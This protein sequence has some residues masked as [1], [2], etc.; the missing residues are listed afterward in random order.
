M[1]ASDDDNLIPYEPQALPR[2]EPVAIECNV[3]AA[4]SIE[5]LLK[6]LS[7]MHFEEHLNANPA[8]QTAPSLGVSGGAPSGELDASGVGIGATPDEEQAGETVPDH[9][10]AKLD[11]A[12]A[13]ADMSDEAQARA[14][15]SEVIAEG[16]AA[17]RDEAQA[18]LSRLG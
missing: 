15:L 8:A 4:R 5:D 10:E 14:V 18:L 17:Q 11:L 1:M 13:Y 6:E 16:S 3:D 9:L 12:R 2:E 7:A